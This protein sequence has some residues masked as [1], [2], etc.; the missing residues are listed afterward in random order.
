MKRQN[1]PVQSRLSFAEVNRQYLNLF[2]HASDGYVITDQKAII[3]KANHAAAKIL[4]VSKELL[5]GKQL[6]LFIGKEAESAFRDLLQRL[7]EANEAQEW[8][9]SLH[10]SGEKP[11][12][13]I[14]EVTPVRCSD[15]ENVLLYWLIRSV[16]EH[17]IAGEKLRRAQNELNA[18]IKEQNVELAKTDH[19]LAAEIAERERAEKRIGRQAEFLNHVLESLS[20]PF[21]V[22]DA[23]D[24]TIKMANSAAALNDLAEPTTCYAL[25]HRRSLPCNGTEH[26]CPLQL[27]KKTKK[28]V[29]LEHIHFDKQGNPRNVEVHGYPIFDERGNVVQMIEY[30]LDITERKRMEQELRDNAEKIKMFAYAVSHDL[31]SPLIG[32]HGLVELLHRRYQHLLDDKGKKYCEQIVKASKQVLTLIEE[33][34]VF[35]KSKEIP[36]N[37]EMVNPAEIFQT[38][39]NEFSPLLAKRNIKW[40]EPQ[41]VSPLKA[42]KLSLLRVF[43]NL[44]DNALK[45]GGDQ[46]SEIKITHRDSKGFHIFSVCD[47]GVGIEKKH[48]ESIFG[49]FQRNHTSKGVEGTGLGLA[50]VKELTAKHGGEVWAEPNTGKGVTFYLTVSKNL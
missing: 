28:P 49:L 41:A 24:Y 23:T 4:G 10:L 50:I 7:T 25:T 34:N 26:A 22:L 13:V 37:F 8:N 31:K 45:Y 9:T 43:R 14:F 27:V 46:L 17:K 15:I 1:R 42:D 39:R 48:C 16:S 19:E 44:I 32:I 29:I 40:S 3:L 2:D 35:I 20:H 47:D 38:L 6:G 18:K 33:L 12:H 36:L 21:Y 11:F 30:S 5:S